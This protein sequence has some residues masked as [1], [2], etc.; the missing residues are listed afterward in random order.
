LG[1]QP[2]PYSA[3]AE[4]MAGL[5]M[6]GLPTA[7]SKPP[8]GGA[9]RER[10]QARRPR[11]AARAGARPHAPPT[12]CPEALG[13]AS[14]RSSSHAPAL[15]A[16]RPR[17]RPGSTFRGSCDVRISKTTPVA[18]RRGPDPTCLSH[19]AST[20]APTIA[21]HARAPRSAAPRCGTCPWRGA[22]LAPPG[23]RSGLS[24]ANPRH[25]SHATKKRNDSGAGGSQ[26]P[27]CGRQEMGAKHVTT[28]LEAV[29]YGGKVRLVRPRPGAGLAACMRH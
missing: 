23:N 22:R 5:A 13:A 28:D 18:L 15:P 14:S 2:V 12:Q 3:R 9:A 4:P 19:H 1:T 7:L 10:P 16:P 25:S 6:A 11:P 29:F 21:T 20:R 27:G 26:R 24:A 17:R 8:R